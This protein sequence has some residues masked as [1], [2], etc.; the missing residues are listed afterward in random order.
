MSY[1]YSESKK[2]LSED[3][4]LV[5]RNDVLRICKEVDA[6]TPEDETT[7]FITS[8]HVIVCGT[9]DGYDIRASLLK[10]IETY[11]AAHFAALTYPTKS[12]EALGPMSSTYALKVD[13]GFKATRYGQMAVS[14]DPTGML[15]NARKKQVTM[16]SIG[17]GIET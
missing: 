5:V 1:T 14:L 6:E 3:T 13:L 7:S 8:A 2:V 12:R 10:Q 16:Y 11:L 15:D 9:L 4:P 17:S